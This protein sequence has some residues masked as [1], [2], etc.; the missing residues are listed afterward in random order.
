MQGDEGVRRCRANGE[1]RAGGVSILRSS[2][3]EGILVISGPCRMMYQRLE[4]KAGGD[5]LF[6]EVKP[7]GSDRAPHDTTN[8]QYGRA[9]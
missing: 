7:Q 1:Y 8:R 4:P 9:R 3:G 5:N 6:Q 2:F